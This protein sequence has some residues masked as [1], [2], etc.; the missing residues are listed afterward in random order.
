MQIPDAAE[1]FRKTREHEKQAS[2]GILNTHSRMISSKQKNATVRIR[3]AGT[4]TSS[5]MPKNTSK[6]IELQE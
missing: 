5:R 2:R 3:K 6:N 1:T 4:R